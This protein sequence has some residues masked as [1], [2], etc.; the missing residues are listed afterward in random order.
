MAEEIQTLEVDP[1]TEKID[2]KDYFQEIK[3]KQQKATTETLRNAYNKE[4]IVKLFR[5]EFKI[6]YKDLR[7]A[8]NELYCIDSKLSKI[9]SKYGIALAYDRWIKERRSINKIEQ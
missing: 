6:P 3:D 2:P 7:R 5:N 4:Q 9:V 1:Y 8:V